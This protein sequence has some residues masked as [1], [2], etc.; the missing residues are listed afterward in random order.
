VQLLAP[1]A[2]LADPSWAP[3][4]AGL[5]FQSRDGLET[6]RF[7]RLDAEGCATTGSSVVLAPT[8][9][10]PDWGPADPPA[11][12]FSPSAPAPAPAPAPRPQGAPAAP[13]GGTSGAAAG[14][15]ALRVVAGGPARQRFR[16]MLTVSCTAPA[17]GSCT[18][19]AT[20]RVGSRTHRARASVAVRAGR[21]ARLRLRFGA[22]ATKA[23]RSALRRGNLRATVR[24]AV[25]A[26]DGAAGA[27]TRTVRLSR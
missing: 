24:L 4:S 11:A 7:T 14:P 17:S 20:V 26:G 19:T 10:Q 27:A 23:I 22:A 9:T 21:A 1:D 15:Q 13:G 2:R 5:A 12:R 25:R 16:G 3:D 8:G 18:A 6:L